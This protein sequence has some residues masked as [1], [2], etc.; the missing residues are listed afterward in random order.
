[1]TEKDKMNT[2]NVFKLIE[3]AEFAK[4]PLVDFIPYNELIKL[5]IEVRRCCCRTRPLLRLLLRLRLLLLLGEAFGAAGYAASLAAARRCPCYCCCW[6][7]SAQSKRGSL[8][9][10][11][12]RVALQGCSHVS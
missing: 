7:C 1:V 12:W 10:G 6:H 11:R 5:R 2:A 9:N 3:T 8:W 4:K